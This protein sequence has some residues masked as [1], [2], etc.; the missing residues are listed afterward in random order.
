VAQLAK[1]PESL[2][3]RSKE[4]L[5]Q[6]ESKRRVVQQTMDIVEVIKI[7]K[8]LEE[9]EQMLSSITIEQMTPLQAMQCLADLKDKLKKR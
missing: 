8:D 4:L 7:P 5:K 9:I 1:M 2:T 3:K 6:L